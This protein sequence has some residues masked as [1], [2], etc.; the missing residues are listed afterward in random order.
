M[1]T[2]P[3]AE[4]FRELVEWGLR[5]VAPGFSLTEQDIQAMLGI[6]DHLVAGHADSE[7]AK[8]AETPRNVLVEWGAPE[9][10]QAYLTD[11][12]RKGHGGGI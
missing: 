4:R 8:L 9:M 1:D 5:E 12:E 2:R 3:P 7:L 10:I 6:H 11:K